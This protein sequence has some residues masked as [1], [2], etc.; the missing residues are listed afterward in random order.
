MNEIIVFTLNGC[1]HCNELKK[2]LV[3]ENIDF[4]IEMRNVSDE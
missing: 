4:K 3:K 1:F 2:K